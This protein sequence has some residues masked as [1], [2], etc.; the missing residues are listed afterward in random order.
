MSIPLTPFFYLGVKKFSPYWKMDKAAWIQ[1][2]GGPVV[3]WTVTFFRW[4][5]SAK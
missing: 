4:H 2:I 5:F 3:I 1:T